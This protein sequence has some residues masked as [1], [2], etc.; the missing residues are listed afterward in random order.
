MSAK[1]GSSIAV[2][3]SPE[4]GVRRFILAQAE[5]FFENRNFARL[6]LRELFDFGSVRLE[7]PMDSVLTNALRPLLTLIVAGQ[8]EGIF[9]QDLD[10]R[11][12][13][14]STVAQVAY[15]TIAQPL[16][17]SIMGT[18]KGVPLETSRAFAAHAADFALRALKA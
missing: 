16:V 6:V 8:E 11:F 12:G 9:R 18:E 15:F 7:V 4:E 14:I 2:V 5:R 17:A 13:L 3:P 10:P 1:V